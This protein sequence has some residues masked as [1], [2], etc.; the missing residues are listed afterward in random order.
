MPTYYEV[1]H[2]DLSK[3]SQAADKWDAMAEDFGKL[4]TRYKQDVHRISMGEGWA[5]LSAQAASARFEVTLKEYEGARKE[6]KAVASLLRAAHTE[7]QALKK[8]AEAVRDDAVKAGMRVSERGVVT[9]DLDRLG[10]GARTAYAHD[11]DYQE[12]VRTTAQQWADRIGDAVKAVNEAD[13]GLRLAL[14]AAVKDSDASDGTING[15]NRDAGPSRYPTLAEAAKAAH[16]PEDRSK[17]AAWWRGLDPVTRGILLQERGEE[18]LKAGIMDP[19]YKWHSP[20]PGSGPFKTEEPTPHDLELLALAQ[21]LA[22]GGDVIGENAASR[23]MEHYLKATGEPLDLDVDRILH[24]APGYRTRVVRDHVTENQTEWR[25]EA[26]DAFEKA[27][28]DKPIAIPVE[29][30]AQGRAFPDS[31]SQSEWFHAVGAHQ[32]NVSGV[33]TVTPTASG[34]P[35]VTLDYQVN[36]WDR[37]NW[38]AG[39]S[40]KFPGGLVVED[41]DMGRLHKVG[42]AREFDMRGSSS[43]Y[44][45][46]LNSGSTATINPSDPGRGG[47]RTDVSRGDEEN[48]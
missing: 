4:A 42:F 29:S 16:M 5:G 41:E 13:E 47:S 2:T 18:L 31:D 9:F 24:D 22:L 21:S 25:K 17:V 20:D 45:Y 33:V 43:A 8:K 36:V 11:P 26:L 19:Q 34:K 35:K 46:E 10:Q 32:Q 6:A 38:D 28:G 12:S 39:K 1:M 30:R 7:F 48:R 14:A 3:L 27:G 15:F 23:N 37:Y 40:T 44:T